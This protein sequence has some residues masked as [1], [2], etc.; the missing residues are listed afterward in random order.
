MKPSIRMLVLAATLLALGA[1]GCAAAAAGAVVGVGTYS[2]LRGDMTTTFAAPIDDVW[3][4]T[5]QATRELGLVVK[6]Q[7]RDGLNGRL[8]ASQVKGGDIKI[9]LERRGDNVTAVSV[10]VG[11]FGDENMSRFVL[12][13]IRENL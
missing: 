7:E 2:Y 3:Q 4:A 13:K 5:V 8:V 9:S 6:E 11:T 10:R 12:D 1:T